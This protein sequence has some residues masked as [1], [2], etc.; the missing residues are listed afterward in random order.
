MPFLN[1]PR[2]ISQL[3]SLRLTAGIEPR[4]ALSQHLTK[5][6]VDG[7]IEF[8]RE[9]RTPYYRIA[10][11]RVVKRHQAAQSNVLQRSSLKDFIQVSATAS[12][13]AR[14]AIL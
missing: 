6:R 8:R 14:P 4:T 5:L 7:L 1:R 10:D 2:E 3:H 9:S 13:A 11:R 12:A